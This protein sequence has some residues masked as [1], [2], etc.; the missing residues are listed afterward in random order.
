MIRNPDTFNYYVKRL[1]NCKKAEECDTLTLFACF[2]E[3][4]SVEDF[5][6]LRE[7]A[8]QIRRRLTLRSV[9]HPNR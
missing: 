2:D 7:N 5:R 9:L 6:L 1:L 4:I 3:D 8:E